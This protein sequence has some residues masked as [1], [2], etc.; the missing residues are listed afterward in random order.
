MESGL[1]L[2][3]RINRNLHYVARDTNRDDW[4]KEI[5]YVTYYFNS[6]SKP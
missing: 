1:S 5:A 6:K 4:V 2:D 3:E